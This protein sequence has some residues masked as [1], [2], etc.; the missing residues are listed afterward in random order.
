MFTGG[1][2]F[3]VG[4]A[5]ISSEE[6]ILAQQ[7]TKEGVN[8]FVLTVNAH[9]GTFTIPLHGGGNAPDW[10]VDWGDN[11]ITRV[12]YRSDAAHDYKTPGTYQIK[13]YPATAG[14][15]KTATA[16]A[17][18]LPYGFSA[19]DDTQPAPA[20]GANSLA[21]RQKVIHVDGVIVPEM[22]GTAAE[23]A[24]G[25]VGNGACEHWFCGCTNLT[26]SD[27]F[28]FAGWEKITE[29]GGG[30]CHGMFKFCSGNNFKM[31]SAFNLPQNIQTI[32]SA[33][34]RYRYPNWNQVPAYA[35]CC[36][37]FFGCSGS[38]FN[39]NKV[40]T[41]P[42]SLNM[43]GAW[44]CTGMF[45]DC[46]GDAFTM[47]AAFNLPQKITHI[48]PSDPSKMM[49]HVC[50]SMFYNCK[51]AAFTMN[52]IFQ[53]PQNLEHG[54]VQTFARMFFQCMGNAFTMNSLFTLPQNMQKAYSG[55]A[56]Q[57]FQNCKGAAF[58]MNSVFKAPPNLALSVNGYNHLGF[59]FYGCGSKSGSAF[60]VNSVFVL[61]AVPQTHLN[62]TYGEDGTTIKNRGA[63]FQTFA[64]V[65]QTQNRLA[66]SIIGTN[67]V[68]I[69]SRE[70]FGTGFTDRDS[71]D[72]NWRG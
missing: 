26:M 57:M 64:G 72:A 41:L 9:D 8:P 16:S 69:A 10:I 15:A 27:T 4:T 55:L 17:W 62:T 33:G 6:N 2:A 39:M 60:Q 35:F 30:F 49:G 45:R 37:M 65:T 32:R 29:V 70:T 63:Y 38:S 11:V 25:K 47:G 48:L 50:E 34:A 21:N 59:T 20:A 24:A 58:T 13:I 40:F 66:E 3:V 12:H 14:T 44:F 23:L 28:T 7:L 42:Q 71:I 22:V 53:T 36:A 56:Y 19:Y 31:G 61:P 5:L 43:T 52:S 67:P 51:G 68:P 54:W 1:T 46:S 18:L